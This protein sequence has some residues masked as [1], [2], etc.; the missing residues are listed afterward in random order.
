MRVLLILTSVKL[1]ISDKKHKF[2][3]TTNFFEFS[4]KR[5]PS[6]THQMQPSLPSTNLY[7]SSFLLFLLHTTVDSM[8]RQDTHMLLSSFFPSNS[9]DPLSP[10]F[11]NPNGL[12][13]RS[14]TQRRQLP[15]LGEQSLLCRLCYG[16]SV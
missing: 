7:D 6:S 9:N 3:Y 11:Q 1:G 13:P 4:S 14:T 15:S 12:T 10:L 8:T 5:S 2:T 16:F